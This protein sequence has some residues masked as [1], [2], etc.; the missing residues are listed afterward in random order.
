MTDRQVEAAWIVIICMALAA[1]FTA[2]AII[3]HVVW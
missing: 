1:A 2:V 3:A